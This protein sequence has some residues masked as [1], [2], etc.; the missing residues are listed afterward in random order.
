M[1]FVVGHQ[2]RLFYTMTPEVCFSLSLSLSLWELNEMSA[3]TRGGGARAVCALLRDRP[4]GRQHR[5]PREK[6]G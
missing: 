4:G 2:A 6:L 3:G 5:L 1:G